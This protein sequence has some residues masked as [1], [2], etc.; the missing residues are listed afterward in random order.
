MKKEQRKFVSVTLKRLRC[1]IVLSVIGLMILC[2]QEELHNGTVLCQFAQI[3]HLLPDTWDSFSSRI[4]TFFL[5]LHENMLESRRVKKGLSGHTEQKETK[6][7]SRNEYLLIY[8]S[9]AESNQPAHPRSLIRV[10]V[11]RM[12]KLAS[13][14]VQNAPS[15]NLAYM[16]H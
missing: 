1:G 8:A 3:C 9:K 13:L 5:F 15:R 10:F 6:E 4:L 11:V 14:S 12:K 2:L 16:T 7:M